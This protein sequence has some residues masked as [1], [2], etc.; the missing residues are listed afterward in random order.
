LAGEGKIDT[1][2]H[3]KWR[4]D[5]GHSLAKEKVTFSRSRDRVGGEKREE[6]P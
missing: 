2:T 5:E 6:E 4:N 1:I 3:I